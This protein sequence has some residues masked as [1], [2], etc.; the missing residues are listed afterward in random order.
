MLSLTTSPLAPD[1]TLTETGL[2]NEA[3][4]IMEIGRLDG[5]ADETRTRDLLRD[6]QG[7]DDNE[8]D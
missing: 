3:R 5:G 6:R 8:S 7:E 1:E 2:T 4:K